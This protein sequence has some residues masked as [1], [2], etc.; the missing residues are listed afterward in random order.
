MEGT[1]SQVKSGNEHNHVY[2]AKKFRAFTGE[3]KWYERDG[4]SHETKSR[5]S[6]QRIGS[7]WEKEDGRGG[8]IGPV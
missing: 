2:E 6:N 3:R 7:R 8:E 5:V 4:C 1:S